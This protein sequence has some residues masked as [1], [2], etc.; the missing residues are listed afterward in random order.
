MQ[1]D[2]LFDIARQLIKSKR[3]SYH[4]Q[5]NA[6]GHIIFFALGNVK[7]DD[8]F[9]LLTIPSLGEP[10]KLAVFDDLW[11]IDDLAIFDYRIL[12]FWNTYA[13]FVESDYA[14]YSLNVN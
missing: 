6:F 11:L 5:V 14:A 12:K 10:D 4:R 7:L 9:H 2:G 13:D 8:S 3:L 1:G